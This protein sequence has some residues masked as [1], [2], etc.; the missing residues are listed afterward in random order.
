MMND[1]RL[2]AT[3]TSISAGL[4]LLGS[5]EM[6]YEDGF[7]SLQALKRCSMKLKEIILILD[8]ELCPDGGI[9]TFRTMLNKLDSIASLADTPCEDKETGP[10][11][12]QPSR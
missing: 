11:L 3:A 9:M 4:H 8:T 1:A 10:G 7:V 12:E 6:S 5:L 2:L